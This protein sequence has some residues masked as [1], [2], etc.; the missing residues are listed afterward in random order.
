MSVA[1]AGSEVAI[2]VESM[3]S[4][5]SA[6]ATMMGTRRSCFMRAGLGFAGMQASYGDAVDGWEIPAEFPMKPTAL[7]LST[8]ANPKAGPES[9]EDASPRKTA[10]L[11]YVDRMS[12]ASG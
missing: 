8:V 10:D 6:T 12:P 11:S 5:N 2:T 3:L 7:V 4:M 1:I 9:G